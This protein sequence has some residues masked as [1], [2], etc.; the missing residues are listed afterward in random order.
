MLTGSRKSSEWIAAAGP[1]GVSPTQA[2]AS[3]DSRVTRAT[4]SQIGIVRN[5]WGNP[6]ACAL[7]RPGGA[8]I[9]VAAITEVM[10]RTP[11]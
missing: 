5:R 9:S 2:L 6:N 7:V 3:R 11:R 4:I 10:V 8:P 1:G